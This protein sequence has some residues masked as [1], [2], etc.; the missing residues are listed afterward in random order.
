MCKSTRFHE[1]SDGD[2]GDEGFASDAL[3]AAWFARLLRRDDELRADLAFDFSDSAFVVLVVLSFCDS[4]D[5]TV[6]ASFFFLAMLKQSQYA[7]QNTGTGPIRRDT[8]QNQNSPVSLKFLSHST[9]AR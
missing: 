6:V 7:T 3:V 8:T 9:S 2:V 4:S 1:P 5:A